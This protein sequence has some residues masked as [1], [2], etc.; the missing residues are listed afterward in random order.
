MEGVKHSKIRPV[1][2]DE[3]RALTEIFSG[4]FTA[5]QLKVLKIKQ[6]SVLGNHYHPYKQFFY[7]FKGFADYTFLDLETNIKE[8][9]KVEEGDLIIIDK[10]IAHKA[11]QKAGNIM[12]EGNEN[13]YT[14][15]E[16]DDLKFVIED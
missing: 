6:D 16:V 3:R 12:I 13:A 5:K 2:E 1:H 8:K 15:P 11:I 14:S 4:T 10:K 9:I 7:M